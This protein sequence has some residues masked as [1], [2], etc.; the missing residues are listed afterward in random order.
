MKL[1]GFVIDA[2][3]VRTKA[4]SGKPGREKYACSNFFEG[5][6]T[7]DGLLE[8]GVG[9]E[10]IVR[11]RCQRE[12][13]RE[14]TCSLDSRSNSLDRQ[15]KIV[16]GTLFIGSGVSIVHPTNP[17]SAA[18]AMVSATTPGE[19]PKPFPKSAETGKSVA[20]T[21]PVPS[22]RDSV[23]TLA[24]DPALK[25]WATFATSLRDWILV[26]CCMRITFCVRPPG[27]RQ[28]PTL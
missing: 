27:R 24:A 26:G 2:Q 25:R 22:L 11:T 5:L 20:F 23:V 4:R 14:C 9:I 1:K 6:E 7:S 21:I 10:E 19:S 18:R 16:Q 12:G 17:A 8:A 13:K 15:L 28:S 3:T